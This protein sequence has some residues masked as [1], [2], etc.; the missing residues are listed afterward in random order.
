MDDFLPDRNSGRFARELQIIMVFGKAG[1]FRYDKVQA[2]KRGNRSKSLATM[3]VI[4]GMWRDLI[5]H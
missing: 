4:A 3:S 2:G 5:R 1:G